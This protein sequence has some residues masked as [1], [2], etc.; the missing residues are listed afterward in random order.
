MEP[1]SRTG[2]NLDTCRRGPPLIKLMGYE[3]RENA[4]GR[5]GSRQWQT[6]THSVP[7]DTQGGWSL[8]QGLD[9]I[10]THESVAH[11][12]IKSMVSEHREYVAGGGGSRQYQTHTHTQCHS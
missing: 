8:G 6:H 1:R 9:R 7:R 4:L 10:L 12:Q 2:R 11:P 5:G 3:Y